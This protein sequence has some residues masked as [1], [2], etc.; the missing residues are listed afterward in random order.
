MSPGSV[1]LVGGSSEIGL[2]V[3]FQLL[4]PVPRRVVLAGRPS[5]ELRRNAERLRDLGHSVSTTKYNAG[6][7]ADE[8]DGMLEPADP[9]ELAIIAVGSMAS[10][11][12]S[13]GVVVNGLGVAVLLH[14]LVRRKPE[15]IVLLSS[16]AAVRPRQAMAAYSVGKQLADSTAVL[17]GRQASETGVRVLVVRPGFVSTRMTAGLSVP[18]LATTP[19]RVARRVE[20]AV[21]DHRTIVW[22][23]RAM[24]L[25]VRV[26]NVLPRRLLPEDWR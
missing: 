5:G 12:F 9:L 24:G 11:S 23:P 2:A 25:A 10:E 6:L 1:L 8:L 13:D 7:S 15:Q 22:V 21:R 20:W 26:L 14:A 17:L 16:A 19:E 18:P 3:L 4:G